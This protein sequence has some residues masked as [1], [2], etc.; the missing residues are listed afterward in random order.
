VLT[1]GKED[2]GE[3]GLRLRLR[4]RERKWKW[5][6]GGGCRKVRVEMEKR[7]SQN[8]EDTRRMCRRVGEGG[9]EGIR[10]PAPEVD[11]LK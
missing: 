11:Q 3:W 4:E 9:K 6:K 8:E 1:C 10:A 7:T 5:K 2:G